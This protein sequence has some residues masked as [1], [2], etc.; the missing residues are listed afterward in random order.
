M[1]CEL[2]S[3]IVQKMD[4]NRDLLLSVLACFRDKDDALTTRDIVG[5]LQTLPD[6]CKRVTDTSA[7]ARMMA[8]SGAFK[9]VQ[10]GVDKG[11]FWTLSSKNPKDKLDL[12]MLNRSIP[13]M[14]ES[15]EDPG[16]FVATVYCGHDRYEGIGRTDRQAEENAARIALTVYDESAIDTPKISP[17]VRTVIAKWASEAHPTLSKEMKEWLDQNL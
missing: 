4:S 7:L 8:F 14:Y 15:Q 17:H 1:N 5:R 2:L 6:H 10:M 3:Q 13:T 12:M 11:T 9:I 16:W